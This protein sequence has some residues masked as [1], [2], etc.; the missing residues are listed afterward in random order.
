MKSGG[1]LRRRETHRC[2]RDD[3]VVEAPGTIEADADGNADEE[4]QKRP[5]EK[6]GGQHRDQLRGRVSRGEG[7][8][9]T[10][11]LTAPWSSS[12]MTW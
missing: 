8:G 11:L 1:Q 2:G 9:R 6:D 7:E 4:G 5:G 10:K 12:D 3:R